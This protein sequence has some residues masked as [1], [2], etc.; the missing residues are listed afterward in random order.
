MILPFLF[1]QKTE[2]NEFTFSWG[3]A[4]STYKISKQ[5]RISCSGNVRN[6]KAKQRVTDLGVTGYGT[7]FAWAVEKD[8]LSESWVTAKRQLVVCKS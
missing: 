5:L 2:F 1:S 7:A 8:I 3:K 4:K 6:E